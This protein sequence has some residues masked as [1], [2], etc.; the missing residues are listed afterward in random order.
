[1]QHCWLRIAPAVRAALLMALEVIKARTNITGKQ[2]YEQ[3]LGMEEVV[4]QLN[5]DSA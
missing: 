1:M 4:E 3:I 5:E 2:T